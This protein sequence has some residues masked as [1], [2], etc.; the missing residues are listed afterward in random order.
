MPSIGDMAMP[1]MLENEACV[2]TP[3]PVT[4][5]HPLTP[6]AT[7]PSE[8]P[9]NAVLLPVLL[10]LLVALP[11]LFVGRVDKIVPAS[12]V[13]APLGTCTKRTS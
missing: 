7:M 9:L 5:P 1:V 12:V 11:M 10:K 4:T 8:L 2:P 6:I 13:V 3:S